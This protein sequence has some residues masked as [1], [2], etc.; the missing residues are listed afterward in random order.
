MGRLRDDCGTLSMLWG[1]KGISEIRKV[2]N[3]QK[4]PLAIQ[5]VHTVLGAVK[6]SPSRLCPLAFSL[7][8]QNTGCRCEGLGQGCWSCGDEKVAVEFCFG[9]YKPVMDSPGKPQV[10]KRIW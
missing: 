4:A 8:Q 3:K 5:K 1:R 6:T 10:T 7:T 9:F 2:E